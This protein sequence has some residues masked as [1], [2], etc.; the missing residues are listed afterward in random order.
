MRG[1]SCEV[2]PKIFSSADE[3]LDWVL[4]PRVI[5]PADEALNQVLPC[6]AGPAQVVCPTSA[7][8]HPPLLNYA[9]VFS[10]ENERCWGQTPPQNTSVYRASKA[11]QTSWL[12]DLLQASLRSVLYAHLTLRWLLEPFRIQNTK[13]MLQWTCLP[14]ISLGLYQPDPGWVQVGSP[15]SRDHDMCRN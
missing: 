12:P 11:S 5:F 14:N 13:P 4:E 1:S 3:A 9:N 7:A 2:E 10:L 6:L 15:F 8:F